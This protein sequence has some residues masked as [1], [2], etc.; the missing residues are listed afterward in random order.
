MSLFLPGAL[1]RSLN[2][3]IPASGRTWAYSGRGV[4]GGAAGRS[5]EGPTIVEGLPATLGSRTNTV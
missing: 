5:G 1:I 4:S 3:R 2:A